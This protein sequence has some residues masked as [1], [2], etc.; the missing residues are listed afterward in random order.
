[1][2][3]PESLMTLAGAFHQDSLLSQPSLDQYIDCAIGFLEPSERPTVKTYLALLLDASK[4]IEEIRRVWDS[5]PRDIRIDDD[6]HLIGFLSA[7]R[8]RL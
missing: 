1:M 2:D 6:E 5:M 4:P 7:I 3:I 8:D